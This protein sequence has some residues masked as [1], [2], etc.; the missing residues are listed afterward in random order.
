MSFGATVTSGETNRPLPAELSI[1]LTEV[2][3]EEEIG[4]NSKFAIRFEDDICDGTFAVD[5][6]AEIA[7][8]QMLAV[9]VPSGNQSIC[10]V[11]GRV[12]K[13]KTSS[14][15]GGPGSW[16]E[17]HGESR[18]VEMDRETVQASW[19]GPEADIVRSV[20]TGGSYQFEA[21]IANVQSKTYTAQELLNQRGTDLAFLNKI[22][23][24]NGVDF[25]ISYETASPD[26]VSGAYDITETAHFR[27]SPEVPEDEPFD[28]GEFS[29]LPG[30]S[31]LP[32]FRINVP[33]DQCPNVTAFDVSVDNE[34]PNQASGATVDAETG[35]TVETTNTP[36]PATTT[37]GQTLEA[38]DGVTRTIVVSGPGDAADQSRRNDAALRTASWF[39]EATVSTSSHLLRSFVIQPYNIINVEGAGTRYSIPFQVKAVTH[40][41][42]AADHMMDVKLRSNILGED[43]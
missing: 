35:E 34:R 4:K 30:D 40:V 26:P 9:L 14:Q 12:T 15:L 3:V 22:A 41:I 7:A 10:L 18:L 39:V 36:D 8:N 11:R 5:G 42:N 13:L 32:A 28:I 31:E 6:R 16:V 21:N 17:A 2:R 38:V 19:E 20:L 25:W 33:Q 37:D 29:L 43:G 24:E 27:I 23:G 1:W